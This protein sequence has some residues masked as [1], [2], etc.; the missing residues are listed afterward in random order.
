MD[1]E[2]PIHTCK[3]A[4]TVLVLHLERTDIVVV[5]S[6]LRLEGDKGVGRT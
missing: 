4:E 6:D 5:G 2:C 3:K 1:I